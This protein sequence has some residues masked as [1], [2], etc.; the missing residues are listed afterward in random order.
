MSKIDCTSMV[1]VFVNKAKPMEKMKK[2]K[3]VNMTSDDEEETQIIHKLTY[4]K[5]LS[6][7]PIIRKTQATDKLDRQ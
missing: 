1:R 6:I 2:E 5:Q 3:S 4:Q 7:C